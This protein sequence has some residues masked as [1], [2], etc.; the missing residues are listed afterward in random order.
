[1]A[2][3]SQ[4]SPAGTG[5]AATDP[6]AAAVVVWSSIANALRQAGLETGSEEYLKL[7]EML[8]DQRTGQIRGG[9]TLPAH[10][11]VLRSLA[12]E[13]SRLL[14]PLCQAA[15]LLAADPRIRP[16]PRRRRPAR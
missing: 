15:D 8:I 3:T 12:G 4:T 7:S 13:V 1:M 11:D 10:W 6:V 2:T 14:T 5:S 16:S 9:G